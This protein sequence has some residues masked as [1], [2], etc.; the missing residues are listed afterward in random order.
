M[1]TF[2]VYLCDV[3]GTESRKQAYSMGTLPALRRINGNRFEEDV[4]RINHLC[5]ICWKNALN[6]LSIYYEF[7]RNANVNKGIQEDQ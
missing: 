4:N 2:T 3:C 1:T 5:D 6:A 7:I